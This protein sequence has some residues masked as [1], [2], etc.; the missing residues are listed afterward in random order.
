[1]ERK[2]ERTCFLYYKDWAAQMLQLPDELRLKID[3]AIKH[4]VLHGQEPDD[5]EVLY[6]MFALMRTKIDKDNAAYQ[7]RCDQNRNNVN[8]RW[9]NTN[10][11]DCIQ[12]N[13][14][15]TD[16]DKDKDKD[17]NKKE[18]TFV[19]KKDGLSLT[20]KQDILKRNKEEFMESIK[21]YSDKYDRDLLNDFFEYWT[22][23][24]K[25]GTHMRWELE[26]TWDI[27]RRLARWEKNNRRTA[28][29]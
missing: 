17:K 23:P 13:T 1:M 5:K 6:S 2:K 18:T 4:Y 27:G 20:H 19:A 10:E 9:K 12:T 11:Y 14:N 16:K 21:P 24:N 25:S 15:Y 7:E 28:H 26:K 8:K 22:E 3:D 29:G